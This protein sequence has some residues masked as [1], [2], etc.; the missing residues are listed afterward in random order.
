LLFI[1]N[2]IYDSKSDKNMIK[3]SYEQARK[4]YPILPDFAKINHEFELELI[5]QEAF[6][7]RQVKRKIGEKFE[8]VLDLFE[9]NLNPDANSFSDM[10]ECRCFTNG[11][12]KQV[13]ESYRHLMEQ[14]RLIMETDVICDDKLDAETIRK[15]YDLWLQEKKQIAPLMKKIR[16]CWQ[17]HFEPKE[18]LEYLG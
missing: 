9:S 14:Y 15:N 8:P 13:L 5:E 6:L 7:L 17:K 16:E 10:Y 2:F 11:E 18:I 4:E 1:A 3:D 12:K